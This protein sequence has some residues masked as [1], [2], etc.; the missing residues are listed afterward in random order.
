MLAPAVLRAQFALS[1]VAAGGVETSVSSV[2]GYG[3]VA[4]G[5]TKDVV[6]R[7]RNSGSST[8]NVS[9]ITATAPSGSASSFALLNPPSLPVGLSG[10]TALDFTVRFTAAGIASYSATLTI[11]SSTWI[12]LGTA[13]GTATLSVATP[14]TGPDSSSNNPGNIAFPATGSCVFTLVNTTSQAFPI[15]PIT[16]TGAG[17][18]GLPASYAS[19]V[20]LGAGQSATFTLTASAGASSGTLVI[21]PKTYTLTPGSVSTANPPSLSVASPCVGPDSNNNVDFGN[22][23]TSSTASCVFT[24][25]NA[26]AQT[27][28]VFPVSLTGTG[29]AGLPASYVNSGITLGA[30]QSISFTLSYTAASVAASG[31]LVLGTKT[32][33]LS[34]A[35]VAAGITITVATPQTDGTVLETPLG[36]PGSY[37][38]LQVATGDAKLVRLNLRS[39]T[40]VTV[41]T[42]CVSSPNGSCAT[43]A[44]P[45]FSVVNSS[46]AG[47]FAVTPG[48]VQPIQVQFQANTSGNYS[49]T[50]RINTQTV[51]LTAQAAS[52]PTLTIGAPCTPASPVPSGP[53]SDGPIVFGRV[54]TGSSIVCQFS[55]TN[56]SSQP[57]AVSTP[58]AVAGV[59]KNIPATIPVSSSPVPF[60]VTFTPQSYTGTCT[61]SS[62]QYANYNYCQ[63]LVI[64][65]RSYLLI[66]AGTVA[67]LPKPVLTYDTT[68]IGSAQQHTLT[69]TLPSASTVTTSGTLTMTFASTANSLGITDDTA[70]QF[71]ASGKRTATFAVT[72]GSTAV[73]INGQPNLVFATGTTAG[74]ITFALNAGVYGFA[75]DPTT[76][77]T[78]SPALISLT[79]ANAT[80]TLGFL[81]VNATGF[82]NTYGA[83]AMTFTFFDQSKAIIGTAIN[84]DFTAN[85]K[86]LYTGTNGG[87]S[88]T[89][90][91]VFPVTGDQTQVSAVDVVLK[92]S[93]GSVTRHL[94]FA[95]SL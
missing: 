62:Q 85:F 46:L 15:S 26:A 73:T 89:L 23:T 14:C 40:S 61:Q 76:T 95:P 25:V 87:S 36:S 21:G 93:V 5:N 82:D 51:T 20:T 50:L 54:Q 52:G 41:T 91:V 70:I 31:T 10:A 12:L 71:V 79:A 1:T 57:I 39:S 24:L 32:Y 60:S 66:G 64:G 19:G 30:G 77:L 4:T 48:R 34:A 92:N 9:S 29:F 53:T 28:T 11:N 18:T 68:P 78:L 47:S 81:H 16:L 80:Q 7:V 49:G 45:V 65:S 75:S 83:G 59:F 35:G 17:F 27:V 72:T 67:P 58:G 44:S 42:L 43:D 38:F 84:S 86:Q 90:G 63:T 56:P 2:Y 6:F 69:I 13:V 22:V 55:V 37:D 33:T 8:L 74:Q 3:Q 94:V 88:F